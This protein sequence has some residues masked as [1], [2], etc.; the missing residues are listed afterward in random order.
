MFWDQ[1]TQYLLLLFSESRLGS[2]LR[3]RARGM[4]VQIVWLGGVLPYW[5]KPGWERHR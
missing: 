3:D 2:Q 4:K 5:K 1:V